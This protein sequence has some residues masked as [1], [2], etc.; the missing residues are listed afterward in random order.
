MGRFNEQ[1]GR[2]LAA[3]PI[4]QLMVI[5]FQDWTTNPRRT[6]RAILDFLGLADDGRTAF[7]PINQGMT[8]RFRRVVRSI[9]Y[10]PDF[11]RKLVR[12]VK[13][14]TG[15]RGRTVNLVANKSVLLLSAPGYKRQI[16]EE[17]RDEIRRYYAEDNRL[18]DE[19]LRRTDNLESLR[20]PGGNEAVRSLGG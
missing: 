8:Y 12:L 6:Y 11:V 5:R 4:E 3:F 7:P 19:R 1:V 13:R 2:Y 20:Q 16:T 15:L 9:R 18:L 10:P 17:L 14:I